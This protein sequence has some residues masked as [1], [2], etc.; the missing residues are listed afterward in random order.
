MCERGVGKGVYETQAHMSSVQG[1]VHGPLEPRKWCLCSGAAPGQ[2]A[3]V[4]SR[5]NL[6]GVLPGCCSALAK[7][8]HPSAVVPAYCEVTFSATGGLCSML[9]KNVSMPFGYFGAGGTGPIPER[10]ILFDLFMNLCSC[11]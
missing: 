3:L 5:S 4:A 7:T 11:F 1:A 2:C 9:C 10:C 8:K 6:A